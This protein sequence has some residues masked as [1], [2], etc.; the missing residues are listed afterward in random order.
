MLPPSCF[1]YKQKSIELQSESSSES[2][3]FAIL[4]LISSVHIILFKWNSYFALRCLVL[5]LVDKYMY[6][7]IPGVG[8]FIWWS[9]YL[10]YML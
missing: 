5:G 1:V 10:Y 2:I 9:L 3:D 6:L 8:R 7:K 4:A